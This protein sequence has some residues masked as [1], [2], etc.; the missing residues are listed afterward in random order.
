[1]SENTSGDL[2]SG[3]D[4]P[5]LSD[6]DSKAFEAME[7][8]AAAQRSGMKGMGAVRIAPTEDDEEP[9]PPPAPAVAPVV[10]PAAAAPTPAPGAPAA[11]APAPAEEDDPDAVLAGDGKKYVPLATMV[12]TR[13]SLQAK[14]ADQDAVIAE[15]NKRLTQLF[16]THNKVASA[17]GQPAAA[18]PA[19]PVP[20]APEVN[21]FDKATHPLEHLEWNNDKLQQ[22]LDARDANDKKFEEQTQQ[23]R[24]LGEAKG[25]YSSMHNDFAT[26]M[27][28]YGG[29]TG[30]YRWLMDKWTA[31]N[32]AAGMSQKQAIDAA[33]QLEWSIVQRAAGGNTHP[34]AMLLEVAK[35]A[36]WTPSAAPPAA[37]ASPAAPAAA[38]AAAATPTP[39]KQ[40]ELAQ[41][42][43]AA[44]ISLSDAAGG[45]PPAAPTL[46]SLAA[47]SKDE[48]AQITS[49]PKGEAMFRNMVRGKT[50]SMVA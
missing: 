22:R 40:I 1:M 18:A 7:T 24:A 16:E 49:G 12:N 20:A 48:F 19:A 8:E 9:A 13:K 21:P 10:A 44:A 32:M 31:V 17:I 4:L 2:S 37:G 6:A 41:A 15:G 47:M 42:A 50:G 28:G 33:N 27:P 34:S 43:S 30:A 23:E 5:A 45:S 26:K 29:D 46:A 38:P 35:A 14:I 39:A 36:G 25:A 11:P 3:S